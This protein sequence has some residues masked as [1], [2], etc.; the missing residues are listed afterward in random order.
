M[1]A[2]DLNGLVNNHIIAKVANKPDPHFFPQGAQTEWIKPGRSV[3]TWLSTRQKDRLSL[4]NHK[5]YVD[6]AAELGLQSVVVDDGWELWP[7]RDKD[8]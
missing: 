2:D 3:F 1:L 4:A 7:Q 8:A 6:G 5:R